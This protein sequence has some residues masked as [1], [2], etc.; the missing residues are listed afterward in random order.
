MFCSL[1]EIYKDL[2]L[3]LVVLYLGWDV[4]EVLD[5]FGFNLLYSLLTWIA[6]EVWE[7]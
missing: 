7:D 5:P 3:F 1:D 4:F 6:A 2:S